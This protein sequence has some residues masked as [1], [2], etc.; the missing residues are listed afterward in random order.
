MV[1]SRGGDSVSSQCVWLQIIA[2]ALVFCSNLCD[3]AA[4][5]WLMS[6]CCST[7]A[8]IYCWSMVGNRGKNCSRRKRWIWGRHEAMFYFLHNTPQRPVKCEVPRG[9]LCRS[10]FQ[11]LSTPWCCSSASALLD[12]NLVCKNDS[13]IMLMKI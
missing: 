2:A 12:E 4:G 13:F 6:Q 3:G 9:R 8:I 1:L 10:L 11:P 7:T 5:H